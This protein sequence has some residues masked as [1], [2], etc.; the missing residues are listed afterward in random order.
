MEAMARQRSF[1]PMKVIVGNSIRRWN[2]LFLAVLALC[3]AMATQSLSATVTVQRSLR[4]RQHDHHHQP[5]FQQHHQ[6]VGGRCGRADIGFGRQ[7]VHNH[8]ARSGYH[9]SCGHRGADLR[10]W[11][12]HLCRRL[13]LQSGGR[14]CRFFCEPGLREIPVMISH[15][16]IPSASCR[17]FASWQNPAAK[18]W[19]PPAAPGPAA[20]K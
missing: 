18:P 4:R 6:C 3:G 1:K 17:A 19:F 14:D 10:Q 2:F 5:G 15:T 13:H 16:E 12:H 7:L 20:M 8:D 9:G 11:R